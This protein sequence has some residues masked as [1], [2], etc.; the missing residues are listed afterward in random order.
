MVHTQPLFP[1]ILNKHLPL[2]ILGMNVFDW[3]KL[4]QTDTEW[5]RDLKGDLAIQE[6]VTAQHR[7]QNTQRYGRISLFYL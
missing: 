5:K 2:I 1:F 3:N 7:F 6:S 4:M